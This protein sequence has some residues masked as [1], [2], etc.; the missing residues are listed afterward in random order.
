L[1]YYEA[2]APAIIAAI[3]SFAIFRLNT[4]ISIG[5]MY[6]FNV[7]PKLTSAELLQG[8]ILGGIGALVATMF[9]IIFR[10]VGKL[11]APLEHYPI[12]LATCGVVFLYRSYYECGNASCDRRSK[13]VCH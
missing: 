8:I 9:V 7:I 11:S 12:I 2:I 4:G 3:F 10:L 1:E 6:H 5:G 13:D